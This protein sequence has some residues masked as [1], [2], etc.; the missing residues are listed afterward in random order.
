[1]NKKY[2]SGLLL[3]T[4]KNI[5]GEMIHKSGNKEHLNP[6]VVPMRSCVVLLEY[7]FCYKEELVSFF[8]DNKIIFSS[9]DFEHF[10]KIIE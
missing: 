9:V 8:W 7:I 3:E 6:I 5:I 10:F 4:R 1:M 2:K